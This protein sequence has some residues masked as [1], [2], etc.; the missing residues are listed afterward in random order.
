MQLIDIGANLTHDSFDHDR[1]AV[2]Q[3]A[4]DAG[5]APL[6]V[7][8]ASSA[9]SPQALGLAPAAVSAQDAA[10]S[11]SGTSLAIRNWG[12]RLGAWLADA[13]YFL[14]GFSVW[15]CF[16]AAVRAWLATPARWMRGESLPKPAQG[17][18]SA[19][20]IAFCVNAANSAVSDRVRSV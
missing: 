9:H 2:L 7:T 4:R 10:F 13:S 11:T 16:A 14:L 17:R 6:N 5:I 1:D 12:G 3:R 19:T 18:F 15:W 8:G 20:R